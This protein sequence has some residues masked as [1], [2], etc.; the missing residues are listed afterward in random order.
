MF[1]PDSRQIE[2]AIEVPNRDGRQIERIGVTGV[3]N[4]HQADDTHHPE[5]RAEE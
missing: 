4:G 2:A 3:N 5:V 1:T